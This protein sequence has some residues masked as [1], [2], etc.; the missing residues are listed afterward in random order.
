MPTN[1]TV[2]NFRHAAL[3][4]TALVAAMVIAGCSQQSAETIDTFQQQ[5]D[6]AIALAQRAES[7]D[8]Q[9]NALETAKKQGAVTLELARQQTHA[10]ID[11]MAAAGV[12]ADYD[13]RTKPG[14]L[15]VPVYFAEISSDSP[16]GDDGV[17]QDEHVAEQCDSDESFYVNK[18]YL[19]QPAS[20]ESQQAEIESRA[21][22]I[23]RCLESA[24][25]SLDSEATGADLDQQALEV[26]ADTEGRV[27]CV[28]GSGL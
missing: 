3:A 27:D 14:G 24:G 2:P 9:I 4:A 28:V 6:E 12:V 5:V 23:R 8:S 22:E 21:P 25:Y 10:A 26:Y 20:V 18:L 1:R 19:T 7:S 11:C 15:I 13:E 17:S 16:A